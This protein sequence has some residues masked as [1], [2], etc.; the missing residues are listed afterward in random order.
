[1]INIVLRFI[2]FPSPQGIDLVYEV[3]IVAVD[4]VWIDANDRSYS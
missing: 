3:Y 4:F 1:M 2:S